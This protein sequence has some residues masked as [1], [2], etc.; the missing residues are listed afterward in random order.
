M[1]N[2]FELMSTIAPYLDGT[3]AARTRAASS[4]FKAAI[5]QVDM[6]LSDFAAAVVRTMSINDTLIISTPMWKLTINPF[7]ISLYLR[8]SALHDPDDTRDALKARFCKAQRKKP[9]HEVDCDAA[10]VGTTVKVRDDGSVRITYASHLDRFASHV[11]AKYTDA[12]RPIAHHDAPRPP[13]AQW[14]G[15]VLDA[16]L[17]AKGVLARQ[18]AATRKLVGVMFNQGG[19][20]TE[21]GGRRKVR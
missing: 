8:G 9:D 4:A 1:S 12:G 21:G 14:F 19:D 20:A 5:P 3:T 15:W 18:L 10:Y 6:K 17:T 11:F 13:Y 2:R 7:A 16:P